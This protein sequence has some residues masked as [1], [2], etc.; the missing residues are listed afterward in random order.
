MRIL[1]ST[2][3]IMYLM[4]ATIWR[5]SNE[6]ESLIAIFSQ[7]TFSSWSKTKFIDIQ[8]RYT[9]MDAL[10]ESRNQDLMQ[11]LASMDS[12]DT[13]SADAHLKNNKCPVKSWRLYYPYFILLLWITKAPFA[14]FQKWSSWPITSHH[15]LFVLPIPQCCN[16]TT[17]VSHQLRYDKF[18]PH[19]SQA[20]KPILL[21]Y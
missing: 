15:G 3:V 6:G 8:Y 17:E 2:V 13:I 19:R 16:S 12:D 10:S 5:G 11:V 18:L 1:G 9:L 21:G 4:Y 7:L 14:P 20:Q